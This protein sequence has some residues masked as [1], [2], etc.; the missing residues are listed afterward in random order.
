MPSAPCTWRRTAPA[1]AKPIPC[2]PTAKRCTRSNDCSSWL[3]CSP[4]PGPGKALMLRTFGAHHPTTVILSAAKDL[5]PDAGCE[6]LRDARKL[7]AQDDNGSGV[8]ATCLLPSP[9]ATGEGAV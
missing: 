6:I 1:C 7:A 9:V 3:R 8:S 2:V 5:T 4:R